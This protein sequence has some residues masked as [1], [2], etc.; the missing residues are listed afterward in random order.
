MEDKP[1]P[2]RRIRYKGK[3]PRRFEEKYKEHI[4]NGDAAMKSNDANTAVGQYQAA[5]DVKAGDKIATDKLNAA[6]ALIAAELKKQKDLEAANKKKYDDAILKGDAEHKENIYVDFDN[7][8]LMLQ[9]LSTEN[10]YL[11]AGDL[12]KD[13]KPDIIALMAQGKS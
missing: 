12:N 2:K 5:L 6:K 13:G 1:K 3:H 9:M 7:E 11:A 8:R 10:P 4:A